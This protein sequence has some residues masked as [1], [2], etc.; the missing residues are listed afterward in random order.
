MEALELEVCVGSRA[1]FQTQGF[2][3]KL[4]DRQPWDLV[5]GLGFSMQL[6]EEPSRKLHSPSTPIT[7]LQKHAR[8]SLDEEMQR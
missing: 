8:L 1:C 7:V 3:G 6:G 4:S 2:S 5:F